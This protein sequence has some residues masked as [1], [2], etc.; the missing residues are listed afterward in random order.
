MTLKTRL[1]RLE[2]ARP[3]AVNALTELLASV[4]SRGLRIHDRPADLPLA[5]SIGPDG[6]AEWFDALRRAPSLSLL[7]Q[8]ILP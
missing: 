8:E 6:M 5:D 1:N 7:P 4:A 2:R 3:D